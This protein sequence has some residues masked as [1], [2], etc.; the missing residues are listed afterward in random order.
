MQGGGYSSSGWIGA[1]VGRVLLAFSIIMWDLGEVGHAETS[2]L[3]CDGALALRRT[4][5]SLKHHM[6]TFT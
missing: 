4:N 6:L 2:Q 3:L 5:I 1:R